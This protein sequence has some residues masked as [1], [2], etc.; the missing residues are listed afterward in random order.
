MSDIVQYNPLRKGFE[1]MDESKVAFFDSELYGLTPLGGVPNYIKLGSNKYY[2]ISDE[3]IPNLQ[4]VTRYFKSRDGYLL[5]DEKGRDGT[6]LG[7]VSEFDGVDGE[8]F[9]FTF[10]FEAGKFI[11]FSI[12]NNNTSLGHVLGSGSPVFNGIRFTGANLSL[13]IGAGQ[14]STLNSVL[15]VG[16]SAVIKLNRV[17]VADI[18]VYKNGVKLGTI[19]NSNYTSDCIFK[20]LCKRH[21]G[22]YSE[23][24][25]WDVN[26]NDEL[27]IPLPHTGTGYK[28]NTTDPNIEW[29]IVQLQVNGGV[30]EGYDEQGSLYMQDKGAVARNPELITGFING[31]SFPYETFITSNRSISSAINISGFGGCASNDIGQV[32]IGD[33]FTIKI[34]DYVLNSGINPKI[35]IVDSQAGA[36]ATLTSEIDLIGDGIYNLTITSSSIDSYLQIKVNNGVQTNYLIG[37]I[38]V[39]L[40][41]PDYIP[42]KPDGTP[43]YPL[44][45]GDTFIQ[46]STSRMNTTPCRLRLFEAGQLD[47][48]YKFFD[49]SNVLIYPQSVRDSV[50]YDSA[51]TGDFKVPEE[52]NQQWN[53]DNIL[54]P[55]KYM[56]WIR[57]RNGLYTDAFLY[58]VALPLN[59]AVFAGN[60]CGNPVVIP[61]EVTEGN[62]Q[63]TEGDYLVKP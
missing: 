25:L 48:E 31:T 28:P 26:L 37:D 13:L 11:E 43:A 7:N 27:L 22:F 50:H 29:D 9:G 61:Y 6:I 46:G 33:S 15:Q 19:T 44:G 41:I 38:S 23:C 36:A 45:E 2:N 30:T 40:A 16:S 42:N 60:Y 53:Y 63:V 4:D 5:K 24:D 18:D 56:W 34:T 49:K 39:K 55:Y 58:P 10:N 14:D 32:G 21:D 17:S 54:E 59:L 47:D 20:F 12:T 1:I 3:Y 52:F 57:E 62:Y 8:V 35:A 51:H